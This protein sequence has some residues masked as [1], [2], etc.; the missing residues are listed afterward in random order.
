MCNLP[1]LWVFISQDFNY[2]SKK[3]AKRKITTFYETLFTNYRRHNW[4]SV[5]LPETHFFLT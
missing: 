1:F 2:Y 4:D 3:W 5:F